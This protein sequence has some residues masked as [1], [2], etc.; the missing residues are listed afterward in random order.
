MSSDLHM[1]TLI[2]DGRLSPEDLVCAAKQA[3]LRYMAITDHDS[4]DGIIQLSKVGMYPD[5]EIEILPGIEFSA[6]VPAHEVHILGYG[7]DVSDP[8]LREKLDLVVKHRWLRFAKMMHNLQRLGFAISEAEVLA[9]ARE[10]RSIGRAHIAQALVAKRYFS[11]LGEAFAETLHKNGPTYVPHYRL[12]P[13]EI[14]ALIKSVG[15]VAVVAH[16]GQI[17]DDSILAQLI[18]SGIDGIEAFHPKHDRTA[19]ERYAALARRHGLL[20]T[21]G[22][23]YHAI[24]TRYP[25]ALGVFTVDDGYAEALLSK[26]RRR[27]ER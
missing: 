16:P 3:N 12:S 2:S 27:A 9:V 25:A 22:S 7:I 23:D 10:A 24:P 6:D 14:I 20:I 19:T 18:A 1:H 4:V 15:G 17:G 13:V 8:L 26:M 11:S 5:P 21:G